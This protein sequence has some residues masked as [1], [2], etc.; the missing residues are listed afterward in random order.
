MSWCH[1]KDSLLCQW[2]NFCLLILCKV[3]DLV[4]FWQNLRY[5][6]YISLGTSRLFSW[7]YYLTVLVFKT[8]T[9]WITLHLE[10]SV[11][12]N[13]LRWNLFYFLFFSFL[14]DSW[15]SQ[16]LCSGV[17]PGS[18]WKPYEVLRIG[19]QLATCKANNL[20]LVISKSR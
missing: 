12:F 18:N 6:V 20:T 3:S 16:V 4:S 13:T 5:G 11:S 7:I 10:T 1:L 9:G 8:I 2:W 19:P 14:V 15:W 17:T